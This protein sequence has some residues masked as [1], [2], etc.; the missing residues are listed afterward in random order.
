MKWQSCKTVWPLCSAN[1]RRLNDPDLFPL[2]SLFLVTKL[3]LTAVPVDFDTYCFA[4]VDSLTAWNKVRNGGQSTPDSFEVLPDRMGAQLSKIILS[5]E[6]VTAE[7]IDPDHL[8]HV[9]WRY[10]AAK[11]W[12]PLLESLECFR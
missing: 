9:N 10:K 5:P 6:T 7:E 1:L 4:R 3:F 11:Q 12:P 8:A 2:Q